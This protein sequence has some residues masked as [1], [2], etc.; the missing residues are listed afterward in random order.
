LIE[1][2]Y[3]LAEAMGLAVWCTDQAGPFQTMPY[4]GQ[5]WQPEGQ[6]ARQPHEYL[7]DGQDPH[8]LPAGRREGPARWRDLV[9]QR[10]VAPLAQAGT[11]SDPRID[12]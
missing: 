4:A 2:A 12:A 9:Y 6:P 10:G 8:A 7:R 1:E 3:R 5:S 11:G